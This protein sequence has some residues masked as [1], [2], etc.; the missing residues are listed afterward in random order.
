MFEQKEKKKNNGE[1]SL[2]S[3]A[4][5]LLFFVISF[6]RGRRRRDC[7]TTV[8]KKKSRQFHGLVWWKKWKKRGSFHLF[9]SS[10]VGDMTEDNEPWLYSSRVAVECL[11]HRHTNILSCLDRSDYAAGREPTAGTCDAPAELDPDDAKER[12][13]TGHRES[14]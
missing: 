13:E 9:F 6:T 11:L 1:M 10:F 3:F 12:G 8:G 4:F 14:I 2:I 7:K 5:K